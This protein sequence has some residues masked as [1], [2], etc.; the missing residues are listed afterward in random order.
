MV[1]VNMSSGGL[2]N[3]V[4]MN[5]GELSATLQKLREVSGWKGEIVFQEFIPGVKEVPSFQFY[6]QKSGEL[7]WVAAQQPADFV[8]FPGKGERWTGANK[9]CM[10][11]L[12]SKSSLYQLR[13]TF[14]NEATLVW[15]PMRF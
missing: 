4:V 12:R 3:W 13:T 11:T 1:K 2:G 14:K 8:G 6:L 5:E 9:R 7:F 15:S 10:N